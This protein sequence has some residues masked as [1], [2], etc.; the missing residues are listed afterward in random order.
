MDICEQ[1]IQRK[2]NITFWCSARADGVD[3]EL[4]RKMKK[5]GC[6]CINFGVESAVQKNVNMLR[7]GLTVEQNIKAV[8]MTHKAGIKTFCTYIFGIPGETYEE[9][10][11]TI[12]LAKKLRS[13]YTEFFPIT[14]FPGAE[15][16][17][18]VEKY[19][20]LLRDLSD[21]GMLKHDVSFEPY[22]MTTKEIMKLRSIAFRTVYTDPL[23][24]F[25]KLVDI[26][27]WQDVK[28][29]WNGAISLLSFTRWRD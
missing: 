17:T 6:W 3:E 20:R 28:N 18:H 24:V 2:L 22:T 29:L 13:Y 4:L 15:L 11:E 21:T 1:I 23:F 8:Q 9:G 14:P 19:G 25:Q 26:R 10:L 7:K 27:S 5:A 12:A 16:F